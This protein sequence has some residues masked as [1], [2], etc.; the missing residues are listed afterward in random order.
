MT[1]IGIAYL[2][3][4]MRYYQSITPDKPSTSCTSCKNFV[5]C[6]PSHHIT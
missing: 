5:N 1:K 2:A 6:D 4:R 3:K